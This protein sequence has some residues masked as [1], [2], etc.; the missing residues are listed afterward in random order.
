[1]KPV[2]SYKGGGK[3]ML[4]TILVR[5]TTTDAGNSLLAINPVAGTNKGNGFNLVINRTTISSFALIQS[6]KALIKQIVAGFSNF[7]TLQTL[8]EVCNDAPFENSTYR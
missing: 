4:S 1:M 6:K 5:T 3:P 2:T 7:T 8:K